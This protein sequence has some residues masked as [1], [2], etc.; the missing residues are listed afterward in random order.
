MDELAFRMQPAAGPH[1]ASDGDGEGV[2]AQ[3][4]HKLM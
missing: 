2:R 3:E 1:K 4:P